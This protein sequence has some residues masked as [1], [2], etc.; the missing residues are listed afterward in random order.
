MYINAKLHLPWVGICIINT[1]KDLP[2]VQSP[3]IAKYIC[4]MLYPCKDTQMP[5]YAWL[6]LDIDMFRTDL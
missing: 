1:T 6:G 2:L 5:T 3:I 4:V